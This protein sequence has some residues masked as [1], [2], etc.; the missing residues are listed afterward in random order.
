[1]SETRF[2]FMTESKRKDEKPVEQMTTEELAASVFPKEVLEHLKRIADGEKTP[3]EEGYQVVVTPS[4]STFPILPRVI[5][6][7][8]A[9]ADRGGGDLG[10]RT[11]VSRVHNIH[12][13]IG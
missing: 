5:R 7:L 1:M 6:P 9:G 2:R 4:G 12:S 11:G 8:S 10:L 3:R 13:Q